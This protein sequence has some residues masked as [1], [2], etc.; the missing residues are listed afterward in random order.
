MIYPYRESKILEFKALP[1][2]FETLIKTCIAF[3]NTAGGKIIIGIEDTSREIIG[4]DEHDRERIFDEF[5]NSLYDNTS[6]AMISRIYEQNFD[7]KSV[8]IIDI[9]TS[10]KRP[11][12]LKKK[13][14]PKG[15]YLRIGTSNRVAQD[16]HIQ[17]LMRQSQHLYF[18]EETLNVN[19]EDLSSILLQKCYGKNYSEKKLL[20]E[21]VMNSTALSPSSHQI[22]VAGI[23]MFSEHPDRYIPEATVI[24]TQFH[25]N[26]GRD[27][28]QTR[29]LT[30]AI[31]TLVDE[32]LTLVSTWLGKYYKLQGAY[33]KGNLPLPIE[34][35]RE[36][37]VNALIH[38][39]YTIPGAVKIALYDN[40]L[41]IFSP[42]QFPGLV[43]IY[44]LGD[45]TTVLRNPH[46]AR[47]ARRLGILEKL[48]S[49]IR[50]IFMS[51]EKFGIE[52]PI[53]H[54][55]GDFVK[56]VFSLR[57]RK[58]TKDSDEENLLRMFRM[59]NDLSIS[60]VMEFLNVSRNTA[61]RKLNL[62]IEQNLVQ[63]IG[64]GPSVRYCLVVSRS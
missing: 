64:S 8:L 38:R 4:I 3:A 7:G 16:V 44:N 36:G 15:V 62:L 52:K 34:A 55:D 39:K 1:P 22:T 32:S 33:L 61:T 12:F 41:E 50:L 58:N 14:I 43:D 13:G 45:G 17:D 30:G 35:L 40:R 11:C 2:K 59:Q 20:A 49:G 54:E 60:E 18:D 42:G 37:I 51:C 5:P 57:P 56:L 48:G 29:E 27:I 53:Y 63:R 47:L 31:P 10:T 6:P 26:E 9:P 19:L 24:C 25:G 46:I 21:K 28:I 23:L